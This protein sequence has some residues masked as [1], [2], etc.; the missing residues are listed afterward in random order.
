VIPDDLPPTLDA[1]QTAELLG[2][3]Y[4]TLLRAVKA[5]TSPVEPLR[6]GRSLRFATARVLA[7]LGI[8]SDRS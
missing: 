2:V 7:A 3:S 4:W 1:S 6:V 5:G 8:E